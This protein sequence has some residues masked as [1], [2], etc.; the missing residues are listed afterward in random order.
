MAQIQ[1]RTARPD[2]AGEISKLSGQFGYPGADDQFRDRLELLL[3][4]RQHT[5]LVAVADTGTLV[6]WIHLFIAQHLQSSPFV[7]IGGLVVSEQ[8]RRQGIGKRLLMAAESW[9]LELEISNLRVRS[10]RERESAKAFYEGM[11]FIVTKEQRIFD[12][13]LGDS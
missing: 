13:T 11:S 2:D 10:R 7:E 4:S 12:K 6:G 1:I 3:S 8:H 5:V 9:T